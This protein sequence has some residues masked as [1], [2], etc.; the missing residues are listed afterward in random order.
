MVDQ[1]GIAAF[2]DSEF[3]C[4]SNFSDFSVLWRGQNWKTAEHAYQ[5]AKFLEKEE[6]IAEQIKSADSGMA[7]RDIAQENKNKQPLDWE[8]RKVGVMED[9]C[10]HKLHQHFS[11]RETL[12]KTGKRRIVKD[13]AEDSFWGW[14]VDHKGVNQLG[15]IWMK[16]REELFTTY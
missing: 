3:E 10:R 12:V 6:S 8:A 7:A 4:F 13:L 16:L 14:G 11:I 9:I 1:E 2:S 5:A 15:K